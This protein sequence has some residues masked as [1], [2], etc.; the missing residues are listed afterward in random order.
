MDIDAQAF[1][2]E[3]MT[4]SYAYPVEDRPSIDLKHTLR[5]KLVL[6]RHSYM[7]ENLYYPF[8]F[9]AHFE[10][11]LSVHSFQKSV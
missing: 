3:P 8:P 9:A 7:M 2:A 4:A 11:S 5:K 1:V 10:A 6:V